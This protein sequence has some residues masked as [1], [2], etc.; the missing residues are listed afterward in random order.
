MQTQQWRGAVP[1]HARFALAFSDAKGVLA[2]HRCGLA[3]SCFA[4]SSSSIY[5]NEGSRRKRMSGNTT[6]RVFAPYDLNISAV[7]IA[8]RGTCNK[9]SNQRTSVPSSVCES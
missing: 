3:L 8:A 2:E 1:R 4:E 6:V 9:R 5:Y 7:Y